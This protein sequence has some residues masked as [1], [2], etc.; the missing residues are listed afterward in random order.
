MYIYRCIY[1]YAHTHTY[2]HIYIKLAT[3]VKGDPK[4]PFSLPTTL[5]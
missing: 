1:V 2:I 3:L 5:M 4:S